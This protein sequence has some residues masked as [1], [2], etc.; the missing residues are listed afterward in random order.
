MLSPRVVSQPPIVCMLRSGLAAGATPL[1]PTR[2]HR[3]TYHSQ[4]VADHHV[5]IDKPRLARVAIGSLTERMDAINLDQL[6]LL[7]FGVRTV[8]TRALN[9]SEMKLRFTH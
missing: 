7:H 4:L 9:D 3:F 1:V 6:V 8:A 2:D 5:H